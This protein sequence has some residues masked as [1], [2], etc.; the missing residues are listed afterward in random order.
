MLIQDQW[1][2]IVNFPHPSS[3][4][5]AIQDFQEHFMQVEIGQEAAEDAL[6]QSGSPH[7][8]GAYS[9]TVAVKPTTGEPGDLNSIL[10]EPR[11]HPTPI[12]LPIHALVC[13]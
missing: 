11:S 10:S 5:R 1:T 3:L 7:P 4:W 6:A 12:R 13:R 8:V 9:S 2:H